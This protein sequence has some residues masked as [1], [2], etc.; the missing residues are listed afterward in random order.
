M[1]KSSDLY[2]DWDDHFSENAALGRDAS[3]ITPRLY[4]SDYY[5]AQNAEELHGLGITHVLSVLDIHPDLPEVISND[6]RL[7]IPIDD[8]PQ[9]DLLQ[10]LH[11]TTTFIAAALKEN[12]T[13]K[14]LVR[15]FTL[16]FFLPRNCLIPRK[17]HCLMGMSRSATVVCA[18]L[19]ATTDMTAPVS[20]AHVQELRPV[21]SPN[22]GFRKQLAEYE[23]RFDKQKP[24]PLQLVLPEG[25]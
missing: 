16:L 10:H 18:Y 20:I 13:N 23:T 5:S 1:L 8:V 7:Y 6:R 24:Q 2:W 14:V 11:T 15:R 9:A 21:V 22:L 12:E 17:V 25:Q 19:V 3:Q 4:L